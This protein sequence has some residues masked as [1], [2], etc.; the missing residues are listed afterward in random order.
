MKKG[1]MS[2]API[3]FE[4]LAQTKPLGRFNNHFTR[5]IY[6][7]S[8]ISCTNIH[9]MHASM[10]S[11]QNALAYLSMTVSYTHKVL[12]NWH[13]KENL[14]DLV[15]SAELLW[16][17]HDTLHNDTKHNDIY[18]NATQHNND[19]Q[20]NNK[21]N[22]TLSIMPLDKD[23]CYAWCLFCW[24]FEISTLCWVLLCWIALCWVSLY[25]WVSLYRMS[26]YW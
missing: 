18:H 15:K 9:C 2:L 26:L 21:W 20:H 1:F 8:W 13:L 7:S 3:Y 16:R 5:I 14:N 12:W 4:N 10:R 17:R 22:A 25:Y 19:I 6:S 24:V 11:F 23:C